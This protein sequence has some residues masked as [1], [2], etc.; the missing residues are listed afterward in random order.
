MFVGM[1]ELVFSINNMQI[2][3]CCMRRYKPP[4]GDQQETPLTSG[5]PLWG[6]ENQGVFWLNVLF[7]YTHTKEVTRFITAVGSGLWHKKLRLGQFSLPNH[8]KQHR[9]WGSKYLYL[10]GVSEG[11]TITAAGQWVTIY[12]DPLYFRWATERPLILES[13]N[14][15]SPLS[16]LW[17]HLV[18]QSPFI[19]FFNSAIR[20]STIYFI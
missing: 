2:M 7:Q 16:P 17:A 19:N 20:H 8:R 9:D 3:T 14:Q 10:E 13:G 4:I 18:Y 15:S 11:V 12:W 5:L 1:P 6:S